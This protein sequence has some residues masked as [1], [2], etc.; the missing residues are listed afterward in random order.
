MTVHYIHYVMAT[1]ADELM[2]TGKTIRADWSETKTD[3]VLTHSL[4]I[5]VT[6]KDSTKEVELDFNTLLHNRATRLGQIH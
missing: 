5:Y 4:K 3:I 2:N 6:E 1:V